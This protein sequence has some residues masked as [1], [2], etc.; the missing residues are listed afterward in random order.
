M[1][2]ILTPHPPHDAALSRPVTGGGPIVP[3]VFR[4]RM[5]RR[6]AEH[7]RPA[8]APGMRLVTLWSAGKGSLPVPQPPTSSQEPETGS[9]PGQGLV[10]YRGTLTLPST[11]FPM[12]ADLPRREPLMQKAWAESRLYARIRAARRGA[13]KFIFHDGPPYVNGNIHMGTALNKSLKDFVVRFHTMIGED[14]PNVPGWDAHG[15]PVELQALKKYRLD[16]TKTNA[17]ELR[18]RCREFA[19]SFLDA[20]TAQFARL[21]IL[22]DWDHPYVTLD[23]AFEAEEIAVFGRMAAKGL[24]YRGLRPVYWCADCT[25]ALAEAEVEF[26]DHQSPAITVLFPVK[27]SLGRLPAGTS[28]AIWTTTPWTL[29]ANLAVAVHPDLEYVVVATARGPVLC[30]AT[31]VAAILASASDEDG[32][33]PVI[34]ARVRGADLEGVVCAHPFLERK[35]PIVMADYVAAD[36]GTGLVHTAPGHGRE[37]FE[38]GR[39]YGLPVVQPLDARGR[40]GPEGGPVAGLFYAEANERIIEILRERGALWAAQTIRHEYAH[41]WRCKKPVLWRATE[42]WFCDVGAFRELAVAAARRVA[43]HPAW[44]QQRMVDMLR[45]RADWCLS[46]QRVWGVPIPV[47]HCA[48]CGQPLMQPEVFDHI[49]AIVRASGADAWW[50]RP[51][52]DFLP[53]GVACPG[54]GGRNVRKDEDILDVWFDSGTTHAAVLDRNPALRWPADL[55]LEGPDQ[56]RG[57]FQSSLLTSVATRGQAPY[58]GVVC[59]GWV[60]DGQGRAMHKSLGNVIEPSELLQRWGVD[61]LRLWVASVDYTADVRVSQEIMGQVG[62]VYRKVRNTVRFLLGNLN[63]FGPAGAMSLHGLP[64]GDRWIVERL[65]RMKRLAYEAYAQYRF[66][67]VYHLVNDFCVQDLSNFYLDVAKDRLYCSAPDAR[68]RR[69]TQA[70]MYE[71]ARGLLTV[72]APILPHTADEAWGHLPKREGD[73]DSVHLLL[74]RESEDVYLSPEG[75]ERW[76]AVLRLRATV[77][78]AVEAEIAAGRIGKAAEADVTATLP[79]AEL[80]LLQPLAEELADL[81]LVSDVRLAPGEAAVAVAPAASPGCPRCWR[82]RPAADAATGLCA[83]CVEVLE[84]VGGPGR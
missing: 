41:C 2:P 76:T 5:W 20:M 10:D 38:T 65:H 58:R 32:R 52:A 22:A 4:C 55:Y 78:R 14:A 37:D 21:G 33:E 47:L 44:G 61:I 60:L 12:K 46:R 77:A 79:E 68:E 84:A 13:P 45:G 17:L 54:C 35:S 70:A 82:H 80:R 29:P 63:D 59:H 53:D 62:E 49:A 39:R 34:L 83:R 64:E 71:V 81:L 7:S 23:A 25:T 50:E 30:A 42:Q 18:R 6:A 8:C 3:R 69:A 16:R 67:S 19:L 66:N 56:F 51:A 15:L 9:L 48:D 11:P 75:D 43:W 40:F 31:R 26:H 57:W 1:L 73:P 24:V 27:D 28:V 36:E 72:I 74:W